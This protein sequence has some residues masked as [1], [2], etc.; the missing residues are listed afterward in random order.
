MR[1]R[2][3]ACG[4][5]VPLPAQRIT[6]Q[7]KA[8]EE[9]KFAGPYP[10]ALHFDYLPFKKTRS[11]HFYLLHSESNGLAG[12]SQR[13]F[14]YFTITGQCFKCPLTSTPA[15]NGADRRDRARK[16][17]SEGHV[18]L[19]TLDH[20]TSDPIDYRSR[21]RHILQYKPSLLARPIEVMAGF[22]FICD[23]TL[24]PH[25]HPDE[26]KQAS[27]RAGKQKHWD[28]ASTFKNTV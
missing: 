28:W 7:K 24:T 6:P 17:I 16:R 23:D 19:A 25:L 18:V 8:S 9:P 11:G 12:H 2:I 4:K 14:V 3:V 22:T 10:T 27:P 20:P 26:K 1:L 5:H 13:H 15:K 21:R